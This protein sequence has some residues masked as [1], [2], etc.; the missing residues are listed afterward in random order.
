VRKPSLL[1]LLLLLPGLMVQVSPSCWL[2][3][4]VE[5]GA[6][7]EP[8]QLGVVVTNGGFSDWSTQDFPSSL[9]TVRL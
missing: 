9:H 2:K 5:A 3:T 6:P 8:S 7:G 4:S 1:L